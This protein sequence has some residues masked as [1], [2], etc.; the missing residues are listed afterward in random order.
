MYDAFSSDYDRFVNWDARLAA[1][2]PFL[3]AQLKLLSP[4][5]KRKDIRILDAACGTGMHALALAQRGYDTAGADLSAGMIAQARQNAASAGLPVRFEAVGFGKLA[6]AFGEDSFD[7]LLCLGNSL[8]HVLDS[9]D[10]SAT[11]HDFHA[12]LRRGGMV[13]LQNRNFDFVLVRKERW[14][15]PQA[16]SQGDAQWIFLRFYDFEPDGLI[17]FNIVTLKRNGANPWSQQVTSTR[18]RPWRQ[19]EML[20]ALS[21]AGFEKLVCYGSMAG[22][23]F[24]PQT[25]GNLVITANS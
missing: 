5:G 20:Q 9:A 8:P 13:I 23:P 24:D 4:T 14:M 25:S 21:E 11:L 6:Q 16:Y 1:E 12:C 2:L 10:L 18:L 22:E 15:E 19:D 7:A 3:E 17:N